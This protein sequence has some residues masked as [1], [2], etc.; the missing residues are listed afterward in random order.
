MRIA[1]GIMIHWRCWANQARHELVPLAGRNGATCAFAVS[2][3][4]RQHDRVSPFPLVRSSPDIDHGL[5]PWEFF[6]HALLGYHRVLPRM[7]ALDFTPNWLSMK[8]DPLTP[9]RSS[10]AASR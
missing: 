2:F 3:D 9:T 10:P 6:G 1:G 5:H 7:R 8:G 4:H